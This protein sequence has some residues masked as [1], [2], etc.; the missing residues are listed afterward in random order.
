[1]SQQLQYM[2]RALQLAERGSFTTDPNPRVGCVLVVDN[3]IVGE[4]YHHRAGKPHAEVNA[5]LAAGER[6]TNA[7]C[8][9]TLEPCSHTGLTP[10]CVDA[11]IVA[12]IRRV[13]VA[14]EDPNPKV[15]GT[16]IKRLRAA[17]IMVEIG[18]L[19]KEA[20]ALNRG[21]F[22]RMRLG[23][24]YVR[25][26]LAMS[27]DGRTAMASGESQWITGPAA[28]LDVQKLRAASSAIMTGVG[29][30]LSDDPALTVRPE[31]D[32][33]Y[34]EGESVRQPLR[35][36]V[37]SQQTTPLNAS[38]FSTTGEVL[39]ASVQD[40]Q[41]Y[42]NGEAV[43]LPALHGQVDL[44]ALMM[45]LGNREINEVLVEAGAVLSGALLKADLID[46]L[47]IYMAP[48]LMGDAARGLFHLPELET[49]AQNI[50]LH[51]IDIRAVGAD[52][53]ITLKPVTKTQP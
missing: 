17:G 22:Q 3:K 7:D 20:E 38:L 24:P 26:K 13:F 44:T 50:D 15:S 41:N 40:N 8:Y 42:P 39:I 46:E 4:A 12:G 16:G 5:L 2:T 11:L 18:L 9:V 52:W 25:C 30:V 45:M 21:F 37:D 27:L 48:K 28:R 29:T 19:A 53:R 51:I 14:V 10:P 31:D 6:A 32:G 34:P 35:V 1:M 33:W 43:V 47:I 23:R 49:M 36:I